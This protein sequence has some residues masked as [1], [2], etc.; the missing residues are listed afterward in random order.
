M[1]EHSPRQFITLS[2][3]I[4][5]CFLIPCGDDYL[6]V[7]TSTK[8]Q[9]R[10]FLREL[11]VHSVKLSQIRCIFLTHHHTD[12]TGFL[13]ALLDAS[14]AVLI[15]HQKALPFLAA[16]KDNLEMTGT[17]SLIRFLMRLKQIFLRERINPTV[18]PDKRAI[19]INSDNNEVLRT[20]GLPA[21][22]ICVPGHTGDSIAL[23]CDNGD[24]FV[25][26]AAFNM[27]G[28]FNLRNRP[29]V[30]EDPSEIEAGWEKIRSENGI[31][32]FV[33]HGKSLPVDKLI[34]K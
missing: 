25:G 13:K 9:Y 33:S 23:I 14:N 28:F 2:L 29:L 8:N 27:P 32:L 24:A 1:K 6:L 16:G 3:G 34:S 5:N 11:S 22:I 18:I 7:D 21:K 26:D 31:W 12:H 10:K 17:T 30:A 15:A 19:I 20:F 4:T